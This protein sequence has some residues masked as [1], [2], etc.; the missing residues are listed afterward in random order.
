MANWLVVMAVGAAVSGMD[1]AA[2]Q[3]AQDVRTVQVRS[4]DDPAVFS[5]AYVT[6][7][8]GSGGRGFCGGR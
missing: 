8:R 2:S 5:P 4:K 6:R 3:P 1:V 7:N